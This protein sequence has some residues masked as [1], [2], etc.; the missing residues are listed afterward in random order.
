MI[1]RIILI[2]LLGMACFAAPTLVG[3]KDSPSIS[4]AV[5]IDDSGG[6]IWVEATSFVREG[7]QIQLYN[8]EGELYQL[9]P[10]KQQ[11]VAPKGTYVPEDILVSTNTEGTAAVSFTH[12]DG[13]HY[14]L[15][16][17]EPQDE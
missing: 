7:D 1:K 16:F 8:K 4:K 13:M 3:C 6:S 10:E 9:P 5:V 2:I 14:V 12:K 11:L 17:N 15:Y